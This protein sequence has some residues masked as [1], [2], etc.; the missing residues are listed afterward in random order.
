MTQSSPTPPVGERIAHLRK[1]RGL[2]Q[3]KLAER[4]RLSTSAIAMYETNRRQPDERTLAQIAEALGVEMAQIAPHLAAKAAG[5][6]RT[7]PSPSE[8]QPGSDRPASWEPSPTEQEMSDAPGVTQLVLTK[9]EARL[10]LFVRMHPD[11]MPFLQSYVT[12]DP[13]KRRQLERAW[14]LI[15]A[16]QG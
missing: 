9:D 10:I 15:Q 3:A 2:T 4:A 5:T 6:H 14:R 12:A 16:F 8:S 1:E 13:D 11:A 7:T